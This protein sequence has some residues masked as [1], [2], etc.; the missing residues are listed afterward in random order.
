[1]QNHNTSGISTIFIGFLFKY[2]LVTHSDALTWTQRVRP[3]KRKPRPPA[4]QLWVPLHRA[5][6]PL[7]ISLLVIFFSG[8]LRIRIIRLRCTPLRQTQPGL[9]VF[10]RQ[11]SEDCSTVPVARTLTCHICYNYEAIW[12]VE[13]TWQRNTRKALR[14]LV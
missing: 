11:P 7:N 8:L 1:M 2:L 14:W 6:L 10:W 13:Q 5:W 9:H 12:A 4:L 3:I